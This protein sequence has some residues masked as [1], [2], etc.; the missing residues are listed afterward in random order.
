MIKATY[1][2]TLSDQSDRFYALP[3]LFMWAAAED[4]LAI[5]ASS[6]PLLRPLLPTRLHNSF[7]AYRLQAFDG[8][9]DALDSPTHNIVE[10]Q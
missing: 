2:V 9:K 6:L 1:L 4:A 8:S 10:T 7:D 5:V 3:P